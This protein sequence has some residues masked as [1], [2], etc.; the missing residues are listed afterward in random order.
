[1]NKVLIAIVVVAIAGVI[2]WQLGGQKRISVTQIEQASWQ[3]TELTDVTTGESFKISDFRGKKVLVESFGVWCPVCL[4]QQKETAKLKDM[5][6]EDVVLV[7][8]DTDP[9]EDA[10]IVKNH[11]AENNLDW[12]FAVGGATFTQSLIDEFGLTV[13]NA[14]AAPV[15]LVCEDGATRYLSSGVKPAESLNE[16][17]EKGC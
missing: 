2:G 10:A 8:V 11:A 5:V 3:D 15:V 14:P 12:Y 6:G 17:I 16:E 4:A 13:V 7:S 9:N 1:M